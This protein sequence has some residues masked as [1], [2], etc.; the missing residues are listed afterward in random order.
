MGKRPAPAYVTR[1]GR[2]FHGD[3]LEIMRALPAES[4]ALVMTSP[5][6]ALRR[7]KAYGNVTAAA[8]SEIR[9]RAGGGGLNLHYRQ[10]YTS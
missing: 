1:L 4:I 9:S 2:A 6:F 3:A 5:P 10:T 8:L 7:Q